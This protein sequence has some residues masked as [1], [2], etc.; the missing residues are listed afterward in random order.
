LVGLIVIVGLIGGTIKT[1][2]RRGH[3]LGVGP[4]AVPLAQPPPPQQEEEEEEEEKREEPDSGRTTR[5]RGPAGDERVPDNT[6]IVSVLFL[7]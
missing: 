5:S 4:P 1:W 3:R 2:K 6:R 7:L